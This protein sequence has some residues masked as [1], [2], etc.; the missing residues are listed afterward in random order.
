[1]TSADRQPVQN[2]DSRVQRNRS[3]PVSFGFFILQ[4]V[5]LM[6]KS[7]QPQP[8]GRH[9]C[10]RNPAPLGRTV[11]YSDAAGCTPTSQA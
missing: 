3:A 8:E 7:Q 9:E 4:N 10:E 1:M 5:G 2:R 6:A 11:G